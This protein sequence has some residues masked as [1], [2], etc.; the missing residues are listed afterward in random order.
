[1]ADSNKEIR[2]KLS[3]ETDGEGKI[4]AL[5]ID[6]K[7]LGEAIKFASKSAKIKTSIFP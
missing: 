2:F 4:K 1:M 5:G 3:V 6:A 7:D